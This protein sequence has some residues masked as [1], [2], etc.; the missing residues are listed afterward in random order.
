MRGLRCSLGL[1]LAAIWIAPLGAQQTAGTIRG[2]VTDESSQQPIRG[3]TITVL[4]RSTQTRADG[5]FTLADVPAGTDTLRVSM[6]GYSPVRQAVTLGA[7][8]A[9][10]LE[11]AMAQQAVGLAEMVVVGYGEQAAGNITG[12]VT[13]VND[14]E[15]NTGRIVS[16]Q[17]LIQN[18]AAG[19]QVVE[20]NEPGQGTSIRIRGT[21]SVNASSEPLYVIDG[22]PVGTGAGAGIIVETNRPDPTVVNSSSGI[23]KGR[24]PLNFLNPGDI[25]SIT[26]L[27]DASSAAIYGA[28]AANGVVLITTKSG[29]NRPAFEY[30]GNV[31]ASTV[32]RLPLLLNADQFRA[33]VET[34]APT[35]VGQLGTANT[36][37]FGEVDH[38]AFGQEHNAALSGSGSSMDYRFSFNFLDQNGIIQP[39]STQRIGLGVSY[40]QRLLRDRLSLRFNARGAR[41]EDKFPPNGVLS[42]A[43]QMGPT[44]PVLDGNSVT[45]FFENTGG[46][47]APDNPVAIF[48]LARDQGTTYRSIGNVQGEYSL[49]WI[50]GLKANLNLGYDVTKADREV[51][52]PS[53]LHRE[54]ATN[55]GQIIRINPT[56]V[57][58][59]LEGFL[60]YVPPRNLGPGILDLT[61]GYSYAESN[62]DFPRLEA[63][64]LS[65]DA[66]GTD[67]VPGSTTLQNT[68]D[69]QDSKLISF[70]GRANYNISDRYLLA[71]SLRRDGSSRFGADNA[72]GNFPSVAGAWR[73]SQEPF[74]RNI[75]GLSDLKLRASWARTGNQAFGNYLQYITYQVG[76]GQTQYPIDGNPV[77]TL[78]PGA[79]DPDIKW[80]ST[81][82]V[83]VGL[84]FALANGRITGAIDWYDKKT[85]DLIF[86][87]PV[88]A[89]TNLSNFI[90]T[91][92][93]SM[94]NRG[95][96]FSLGTRLL[97]G[98]N[99]GLSWQ[100]DF[101]AAHNHNEVLT[102]ESSAGA[103]QKIL[104]GDVA[105]GV[106]TK[107]QVLTPGQPV[108]SFYVFEHIRNEN[109][110]PIYANVNGDNVINDQDL[111][112]D[113]NGD[114]IINQ[115][116]LRPF[117]DP[118]PNWILGHSSYLAYGKWD[119][120]VTLRAY[121]GN[122][123]Y[124]NVASN[125]G[126]FSAL[127]RES[128]YNLHT[129][130]LSTEFRTP[131][132]QSDFYVEDASFLRMDNLTLGYTF[133]F[134][135]RSAR[136]FGTVQNVFTLTGYDGVDPTAGLNGIDNNIYPRSRTFSSGLSFRF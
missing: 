45:G 136:L 99:R 117:H 77:T 80:E 121:L 48:N 6:I 56:Q 31:S 7:G 24:D 87:V 9:L 110:R 92:I 35:K 50:N 38:T 113:Q 130:V 39:A 74:F 73:L 67:G 16:P 17:E 84:D 21:T 81:R 33:A 70:F 44:Q 40:N 22:V 90:T 49:P 107:I 94:R 47:N 14:D 19:V 34:F 104:V 30:S 75:K 57:N 66:L 12:A 126:H 114:G 131:Q 82:S 83:D 97:D 133:D 52:N 118:A 122:Y 23:A 109:G 65:S 127:D 88:P 37:W 55:H 41:T 112:V 59:V 91:N 54:I 36:D 15:F 93:G 71:L 68:L 63:R 26:V 61:G 129:S 89:G 2:R 115:D 18:K 95:V 116:D 8:E 4:G 78:R 79:V 3:A 5:G 102:I 124:N 43:A 108:N 76:D 96:E 105:G 72:W 100:A 125:Q 85:S 60:N 86:R 46:L 134:G 101:T 1:L 58:T 20:N 120:G 128:P 10:D 119:L 11:F 132:Y 106:G 98:G 27:R 103:G 123:S 111:Y 29:R 28:N 69:V 135:G 42:N 13:Q 64:G 53:V 62:A 51:F 25:E 32:T